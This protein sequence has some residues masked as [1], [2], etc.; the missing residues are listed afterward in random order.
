MST[1]S[2]SPRSSLESLRADSPA[3]SHFEPDFLAPQI[4]GPQV[5][6]GSELDQKNAIVPLFPEDVDA[7]RAA[8]VSFRYLN[9][10]GAELTH[11]NKTTFVLPEALSAKLAT[12]SEMV[13]LGQGIGIARGLHAANFNDEEAI[14]AYAGVNAHVAP[15][16]A[17][18]DFANQTLSKLLTN[19]TGHIRDATHEKVPE[20][21]N[22]IGLAG[23]KIT[24]AM[25]Y[26]SDR[27]SGDILSMYL[28]N[29]GE[30][31]GDQ[32][33]AS[34]SR[35]YNELLKT[36]PEVLETM[37][38]PDWPFELKLKDGSTIQ[39]DGPVLFF[40]NNKPILQLVKAPLE[41]TPRIPR[42]PSMTPLTS[43]QKHAM[44]TVQAL[45]AKYGTK[46]TR[47]AGDIQYINNLGVL[48]ARDA[49]EGAKAGVPSTRHTLRM[50]LKDDRRAWA[51]PESYRARFDNPF[52]KRKEEFTIVDLDPWRKISGRESHG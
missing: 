41:G 40:A 22:G 42:S 37:A 32:Y 45:A 6:E 15:L 39:D 24:S 25:D 14:I 4:Q 12:I 23:S 2:Y 47:Q 9:H 50:F 49:Y 46:L 34:W 7:V 1:S 19:K 5:W 38:A 27:Y 28:R 33:V 43:S 30:K 48:H 21:A 29:L 44:S 31:G 10:P 52:Q 35:I 17:T 51:K 36:E 3:P 16:R 13:H 11:I 20:W 8:V 26:H 18:D